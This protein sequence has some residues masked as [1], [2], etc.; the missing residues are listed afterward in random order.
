M[1]F[2]S[3]VT[4]LTI[5]VGHPPLQPTWVPHSLHNHQNFASSYITDQLQQAK[6]KY[7][8]DN[9]FDL[10]KHEHNGYQTSKIQPLPQRSGTQKTVQTARGNRKRL[11]QRRKYLQ[12]SSK[13]TN[14]KNRSKQ[15]ENKHQNLKI[16]NNG[17]L[18]ESI[19]KGGFEASDSVQD[20]PDRQLMRRISFKTLASDS[21]FSDR[22]SGGRAALSAH[23]VL[24]PV[25][26]MPWDDM[27]DQ[28]EVN[29]FILTM[30]IPLVYCIRNTSTVLMEKI[31]I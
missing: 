7:E 10:N 2:P 11:P 30:S 22:M 6:L 17:K 1:S 23:L 24:T 5:R 15:E 12:P 21:Q 18:V 25:A 28:D 20:L 31:V 27:A 19:S 29:L 8:E 16:L 13:H 26:P 4:E 9:P 14:T 3:P